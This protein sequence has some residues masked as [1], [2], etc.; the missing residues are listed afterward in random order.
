ML[1]GAW[2]VANSLR[3]GSTRQCGGPRLLSTKYSTVASAG[4]VANLN[5]QRCGV[6]LTSAELAARF[7]S[8][9]SMSSPILRRGLKS[10][11]PAPRRKTSAG[12]GPLLGF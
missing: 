5:Y 1:D 6:E 10:V 2:V 4:S 7:S 3:F 8:R 9:M 12:M 11:L